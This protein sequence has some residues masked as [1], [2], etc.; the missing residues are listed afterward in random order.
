MLLSW[1]RGQI[2]KQLGLKLVVPSQLPM[3]P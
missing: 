1:L 2:E 3:P